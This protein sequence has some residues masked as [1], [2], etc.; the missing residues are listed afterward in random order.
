MGKVFGMIVRG[1]IGQSVPNHSKVKIVCIYIECSFACEYWKNTLLFHSSGVYWSAHPYGKIRHLGS[2]RIKDGWIEIPDAW[3]LIK[4]SYWPLLLPLQIGN[5]EE[6]PLIR[7]VNTW[8]LRQNGRHFPDAFLKF[9]FLKENCMLIQISLK[10]V[11]KASVDNKLALV[12]I[13]LTNCAEHKYLKQYI[14]NW[15]PVKGNMT[16]IWN[17]Y[18]V[19]YKAIWWS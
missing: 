9:I 3:L 13:I 7:L 17:L 11:P 12:Q 1:G 18:A 8:R 6:K 10:S 19:L 14:E 15:M 4:H 2:S 5:W 16:L